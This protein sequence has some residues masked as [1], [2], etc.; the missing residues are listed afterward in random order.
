MN[1]LTSL[2]NGW[3]VQSSV[4][5]CYAFFHKHAFLAISPKCDHVSS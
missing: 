2:F 4:K 5:L 1:G 3:Y